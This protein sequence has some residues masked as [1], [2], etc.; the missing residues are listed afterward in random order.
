MLIRSSNYQRFLPFFVYLYKF[1]IPKFYWFFSSYFISKTIANNNWHYFM[2]EWEV[3]AHRFWNC[4]NNIVTTKF[5]AWTRDIISHDK[6]ENDMYM[7]Y[8]Y[9]YFTFKGFLFDWVD[10]STVTY[11]KYFNILHKNRLNLLYPGRIIQMPQIHILQQKWADYS[12]K[13][14]FSKRSEFGKFIKFYKSF[15]TVEFLFS[16][17]NVHPLGS[18]L[19]SLKYEDMFSNLSL[20]NQHFKYFTKYNLP[21]IY[22][23]IIYSDYKIYKY[24]YKNPFQIKHTN[25]WV[26]S[27]YLNIDYMDET[28]VTIHFDFYYTDNLLNL[29]YIYKNKNE[30]KRF[31]DILSLTP[32]TKFDSWEYFTENSGINELLEIQHFSIPEFFITKIL[33]NKF[34]I[35]EYYKITIICVLI[36]CK[37]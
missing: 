1:V 19:V 20:T 32:L 21:F 25:L 30:E 4:K 34:I 3:Y 17:D 36:N 7:Q 11:N 8:H 16:I 15:L 37:K 33:L 13:H 24:P 31:F 5:A 12:Y 9:K 6:D 14:F 22:K 26:L 28:D 35:I 2:H 18:P 23:H 29:F 10:Y 27:P